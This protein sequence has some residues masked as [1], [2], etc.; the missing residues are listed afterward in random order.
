MDRDAIRQ[1][2]SAVV[3]LENG[4]NLSYR[5]GEHLQATLLVSNFGTLNLS[6]AVTV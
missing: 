5:G 4:I 6:D 1:F 3:L 2:N